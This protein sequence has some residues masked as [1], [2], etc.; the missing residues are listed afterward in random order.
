MMPTF[1]PVSPAVPRDPA[2]CGWLRH[3]TDGG[4]EAGAQI[5]GELRPVSLCRVFVLV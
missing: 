3:P 4:D 2:G 5:H 1:D